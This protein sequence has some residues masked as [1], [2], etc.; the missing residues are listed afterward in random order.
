MA[1]L[2]LDDLS[3]AFRGV[4]VLD[5]VSRFVESGEKIGLL[6]RNGTGKTTLLRMIA[7][8]QEPDAGT[9][10]LASGKRASFLPQE[11][12]GDLSGQVFGVVQEALSLQVSEGQIETWEAEAKSKQI[13]DLMGLDSDVDI[14]SLS[15]G[16]KR[17]VL[18]A[19]ALVTEPDLLLL[20]EPTNHLDL[21]TIEWLEARLSSHQGAL[22]IISHDRA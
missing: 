3:L 11:V 8:D 4:H 1:L 19:R 13:I 18:L 12:P 14:S 10:V 16:R 20:D 6:G 17:R 21:P 2:T 5:N 7:G 22:V 15:A 9:C